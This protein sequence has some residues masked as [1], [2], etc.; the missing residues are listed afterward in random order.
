[1]WLIGVV[2]LEIWDTGGQ[3][4]FR[5][6]APLYYRGAA[7]ALVVYSITEK[8]SLQAVREYELTFIH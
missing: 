4:R 2:Q 8:E 5:S 1:M 7:A 3:E 6:M